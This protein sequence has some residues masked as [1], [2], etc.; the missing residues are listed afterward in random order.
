ME[1]GAEVWGSRP[2]RTMGGWSRVEMAF[3][4]DSRT[5]SPQVP[6]ELSRE[7][8]ME[9]MELA[10]E[11]RRGWNGRLGLREPLL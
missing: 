7:P 8:P 1:A 6:L 3:W 4:P 10:V 5:A 11:S 2:V 9:C